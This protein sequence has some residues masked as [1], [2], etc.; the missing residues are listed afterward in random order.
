MAATA[1][2]A[3]LFPEVDLL[4]DLDSARLAKALD[5]MP[6]AIGRR[7]RHVVEEIERVGQ[8]SSAFASGDLKMAGRLLFESHESSRLLFENST[9]ESQVLALFDG[10]ERGLRTGHYTLP[11]PITEAQR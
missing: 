5:R 9:E 2:A 7:A 10:F 1:A 4:A 8:A 3:G 6:D 11:N